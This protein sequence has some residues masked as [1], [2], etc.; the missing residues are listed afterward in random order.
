MSNNKSGKKIAKSLNW[1]VKELVVPLTLALVA[2]QFVVQAFRIPSPSMEKSLLVGDML[3]GLKLPFGADIPFTH[4][5]TPAF[6][7]PDTNDILIFKYPGEPQIPDQNPERYTHLAN[8]LLFGNMY[9]DSNPDKG[10]PSLVHFAEGP[11]DFIKRCVA[12]SGQTV[13]FKEKRLYVDGKEKSIAG[14]GQ[15]TSSLKNIP[16]R[17]NL[18]VTRLPN[19]GDVYN[20]DTLTLAQK[21]N[22]RSL[23]N[24]EN[25]EKKFE[26]KL[27]LWSDDKEIEHF[28]FSNSKVKL[29]FNEQGHPM[30]YQRILQEMSMIERLS[31]IQTPGGVSV[32]G[33]IPFSFFKKGVK[34]GYLPVPNLEKPGNTRKIAYDYFSYK[35]LEW[36][37]KEVDRRN[38]LDSADS[39]FV[40]LVVKAE[41]IESGKVMSEYK[42]KDDVYFMVGD[43]RDNSA[44]SR[45]WGLVSRKH[46][47]ARAFI[48]YFSVE[49]AGG[50]TLMNPFTWWK[51]PFEIN[52][53]RIG[54]LIHEY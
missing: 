15:W 7:E 22:L 21:F 12:K 45:Y 31:P 16:L 24:Q 32:F 29:H 51:L 1:F 28:V 53:T 9:W 11:K 25:P 8:L 34:S 6:I 40:P 35:D 30:V 4:A 42:V 52:W 2:I 43:N 47:K 20:L 44:D 37:G 49:G 19:I 18:P 10:Q 17:D 48:V 38:A 13:E 23:M 36:L 27:S 46:I 14:D 33:T 41:I 3:L 5:K 39:N 50:F 54:R 26:M